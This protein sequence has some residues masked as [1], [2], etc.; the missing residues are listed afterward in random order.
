MSMVRVLLLLALSGCALTSTTEPYYG[1]RWDPPELSGLS[2]TEEAG[3]LGGGTVTLSGSGFG[4]DANQVT[5]LFGSKN[6]V[7]QSIS[8]GAITVT[9]PAGPL[10]GG[11]V[12]VKVLTATGYAS[13]PEPYVYDVGDVYDAETSFVQV[14]NFWESCYGGLSSRLDDAYGNLGC[15]TIAYIGYSGIDGRASRYEMPFPRAHSETIGFFGGTDVGNA[16]WTV[17]RPGQL[18]FI[19][20]ADDLLEDVGEVT[21]TNEF[22]TEEEPGYCAD[23]DSLAVYYYGG[24]DPEVP[25]PYGF[26]LESYIQGRSATAEEIAAEAD[27][28]TADGRCDDGMRYYQTDTLR[29]CTADDAVGIPTHSYQADWAPD[30]NFFAASKRQLR[31][32]SIDLDAP[33]VGVE[34]ARLRLPEPLVVYNEEGFTPLSDDA[35]N[36]AD[37]W[38]ILPMQYCFDDD[39]NGERANDNAL[40]FA[41]VPS[42]I[43]NEEGPDGAI[44]ESWI[45]VTFTT[46]VLNWFGTT[47][48]PVRASIVVPDF[49][50]YSNRDGYSRLEVPAELLYQLPTVQVPE[51]A[52]G[53]GGGL[54]ESTTS[55]WGYL[56]VT[57]ERITDYRI[58]SDDGDLVF[59]YTTGDFGFIDWTNPVDADGCHNCLDDDG[60]GWADADDPDCE[61]GG[62]AEKGFGDAACND[63]RDNDRDAVRDADDPECED[64]KD[65]DE[66]N[67]DDGRDNDRDG[68][69]DEADPECQAG[70]NE[71]DD[72]SPCGNG[73]DDDGDGWTDAADPDCSAGGEELGYGSSTCNDGLDNDEDGAA[74]ALDADCVD[75]AADE[76]APADDTGSGDT[77]GSS[78]D[79]GTGGDSGT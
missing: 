41:W 66:S 77:G 17:Q 39:G 47:G 75:A 34:G 70:G 6:A 30:L 40:T 73:V 16:G 19:F 37:L 57:F 15:N 12:D 74:D 55:D 63:G 22:W 43:V 23:V 67:C 18:G 59:S 11:P 20:G 9:V 26:S 69:L 25:D 50:E 28:A 36:A 14:N 29:F 48:Y 27:E 52:G 45:R 7:I 1:G 54:L 62:T 2:V 42:D 58:P 72:D 64:A 60:D 21:L 13:A 51:A 38:A 31:P 8:D 49:H 61:G 32:V 3:N 5:V 53:F 78:G 46:L 65:D 24:G 33:G 4:D 71:N 68:Y 76:G 79:T 35:E 56:I 10:T 44:A